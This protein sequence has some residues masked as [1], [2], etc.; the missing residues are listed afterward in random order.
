MGIDIV[1]GRGFTE[2]DDA[3]SAPVALVNETF[4]RRRFP[5][6]DAVGEGLLLSSGGSGA[7]APPREIVGVVRDVRPLGFESEPRPEVYAPLAQL[8]GRSLTYVVHADVD[9]ASLTMPVQEAIW[10]V[11]PYEAVWAAEPMTGL[12][13][14][15][16]GERRFNLVLLS[17]FAGI[18]L[19][20][21][22]TGLYG[23]IAYSVEERLVELGV[24]R[25]LG[26]STA[27]IVRMVVREAT[28]LAGAGVLIGLAAAALL[29]RVLRGMLYEI[30]PVD[31]LTFA[32]LS[33]VVMAVALLA[34]A[35]PL[36]RAVRADPLMALRSGADRRGSEGR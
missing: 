35:L 11:N 14:E 25:A 13:A 24:R 20:L 21:T 3:A 7:A 34:T 29:T 32:V 26:G 16:T 5:G 22:A 12:L 10:S 6:G 17:V 27:D 23:L 1:T 19:V 9:P 18:A 30:D 8:P 31:P 28:L 33:A 2:V 15:L 4:A 36:R